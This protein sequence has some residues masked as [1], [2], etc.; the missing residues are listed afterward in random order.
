M[1]VCNRFGTPYSFIFCRNRK[2]I[3]SI[4]SSLAAGKKFHP[5][6]HFNGGK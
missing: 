2:G 3:S 1:F 6:D 5:K 4:M